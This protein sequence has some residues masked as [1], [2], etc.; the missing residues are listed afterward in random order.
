MSKHKMSV[1]LV[2]A[3]FFTLL[4]TE[5]TSAWHDETHLAIA[6]AAGYQKWYNATGADMAKIKAGNMERHNHHVNN[7]MGTVVT[8]HMVLS[9]V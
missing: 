7:P 2:L 1:L 8:E 9:Q 6:K 5:N 4:T 3:A